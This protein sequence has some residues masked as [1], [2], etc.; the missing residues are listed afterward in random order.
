MQREAAVVRFLVVS[1]GFVLVGGL[2]ALVTEQLALHAS[3][4]AHHTAWADLFFRYFTHLAD[5]LVPTALSLLLLMKDMRS[6]LMMGLSCGLSALITQFLKRVVFDSHDRP[7]MF[8]DEL[9]TMQWVQ[10]VDLHNHLSFPSGHSTAAWSMCFALAIIIGSGRW[11][12][13]LAFCAALLAFSRVYLSQH[14]TE[15]VVFGALIGT[16][17]ALAMYLW[18]YRSSFSKRPW[19][20]RV[21]GRSEPIPGSKR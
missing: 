9:G 5:G 6:F 16:L 20:Q 21:P 17:C 11:A 10:D 4:N 19:L 2:A 15:D 14:F 12:I 8:R 18:L 1:V 13:P 3:I 7:A